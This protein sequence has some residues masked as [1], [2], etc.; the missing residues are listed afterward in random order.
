MGRALSFHDGGHARPASR[1]C[2]SWADFSISDCAK[3]LG[4]MLGPGRGHRSW[5][6]AL[7]KMVERA[8]LWRHIGGGLLVTLQAYRT[9]IFPLAGFLLQLGPFQ[10]TWPALEHKLCSTLFPGPRCWCSPAIFGRLKALGVP[11]R[12]P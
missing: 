6:Q 8:K 2:P 5:T 7:S 4:F 1:S 10:P 9:Y 11:C 3:Y 12:A